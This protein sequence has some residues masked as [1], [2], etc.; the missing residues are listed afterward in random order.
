[1]CRFKGK[2]K[3]DGKRSKV[4]ESDPNFKEK[5]NKINNERGGGGE[6]TKGEE[7]RGLP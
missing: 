5:H 7:K 3:G 4:F 2:I 1:M 6:R